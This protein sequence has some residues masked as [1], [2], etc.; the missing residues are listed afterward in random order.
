MDLPDLKQLAK[1]IALCRKTG[2]T[3]LE[4]GTLRLELGDEPQPK[5]RAIKAE[6][7]PVE[8][9]DTLNPYA[10]FPDRILTQEELVY[11]SAGGMPNPEPE[12]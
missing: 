1:V 2:V 5:T 4:C 3:K 8:N 12:Q 7:T 10:N 11:F 9:T 6:R